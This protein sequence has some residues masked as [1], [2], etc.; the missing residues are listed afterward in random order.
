[1]KIHH[2]AK[3]Q[4]ND[5][6]ESNVLFRKQHEEAFIIDFESA[7]PHECHRALTIAAGTL[8]PDK[9]DFGCEET[10]EATIS[11]TL[12]RPGEWFGVSYL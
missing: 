6:K 4:H 8:R 12:W 2:V 9:E 11:C 10:Y 3:I 5:F 1:M 7:T